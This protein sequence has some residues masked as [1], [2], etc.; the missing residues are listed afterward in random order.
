[1][2]QSETD[3]SMRPDQIEYQL[4]TFGL[5]DVNEFRNSD[6]YKAFCKHMARERLFLDAPTT[7]TR[8]YV[9]KEAWNAC[10]AQCATY[11]LGQHT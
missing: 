6:V 5:L 1:M 2:D 10:A 3:R 9:Y 8:W 4:K 11:M 7:V